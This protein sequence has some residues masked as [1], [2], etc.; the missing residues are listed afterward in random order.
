MV[1]MV[2]LYYAPWQLELREQLGLS[3]APLRAKYQTTRA[4]RIP[5][6]ITTTVLVGAVFLAYAPLLQPGPPA[7]TPDTLQLYQFGGGMKV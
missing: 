7:K 5:D 2:G 1:V 3:P 6:P 4:L